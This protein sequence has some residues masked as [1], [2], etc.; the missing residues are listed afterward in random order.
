[1]DPILVLPACLPASNH[2]FYVFLKAFVLHLLPIVT[3]S[4]GLEFIQPVLNSGSLSD[5]LS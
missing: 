3:F 5:L 1:M 4:H 2:L